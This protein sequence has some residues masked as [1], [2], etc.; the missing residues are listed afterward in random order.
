MSAGPQLAPVPRPEHVPPELVVDFDFYHIPGADQDVHLAWKRLHSGPRIFWTPRNGGHWV[1]TRGEDIRQL[2]SDYELFS[3]RFAT[4]PRGSTPAIPVESDPPEHTAYRSVISPLFTPDTLRSAEKL[5]RA[6]SIELIEA[7]LAR[8]ECEFRSEIGLQVPIAVFLHLVDL[9]FE[10]R[11]LLLPLSETRFRSPVAKERDDAKS[12]IIAHISKV[13]AER[14]ARPGKDFISRILQTQ[15]MVGDRLITDD[16]TSNILATVMSGG[17][18]TVA[19][20]MGFAMRFLAQHP[21]HRQQLIAEPTLIPNAVDELIRRHGITGTARLITRD[22][23]FHGAPLKKG[24]QILNPNLLYGLD[25]TIFADALNVDFRRADAG[26]HAAFG[27]G[28]HRCPG[29]NLARME[30]RILIG[31]WLQRI[32]Q[33]RLDPERPSRMRTGLAN[34]IEHMWLLWDT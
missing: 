21:Q 27:Y 2:Q 5:V 9:P 29:A 28:P 26:Q 16:E 32:P 13:V 6:R 17:L 3:Y 1:A 10:D 7:M 12:A 14:R 11:A 22:M 20:A 31:E 8:G 4:I 30:L 34:V 25:E 19:S 23:D 33:F 24:E 18:D 15:V